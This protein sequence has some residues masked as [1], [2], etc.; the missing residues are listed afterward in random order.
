M[1]NECQMCRICDREVDHQLHKIRLFLLFSRRFLDVLLITRVEHVKNGERI[2]IKLKCVSWSFLLSLE[3][4]EREITSIKIK[5]NVSHVAVVLIE[6]NF[7]FNLRSATFDSP[8]EN[9]R[10][11]HY[12][13]SIW[14]YWLYVCIQRIVR[15]DAQCT[16]TVH[17]VK[18]G[19]ICQYPHTWT[20]VIVL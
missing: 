18:Y 12:R 17:T 11:K 16:C 14:I 13:I 7:F 20:N 4:T 8:S 6:F 5:Q 15:V 9:L 10:K 3:S 1:L 2:C 19:N